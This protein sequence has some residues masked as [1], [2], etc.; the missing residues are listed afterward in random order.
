MIKLTYYSYGVLTD[1][2]D[3]KV[4]DVDNTVGSDAANHFGEYEDD[5]V[6]IR[7]DRLKSDFEILRDYRTY[8]DI[9]AGKPYLTGD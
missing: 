4:E 7:N 6:Y 5:A 1:K 8:A 9:V 2:N 3:Q